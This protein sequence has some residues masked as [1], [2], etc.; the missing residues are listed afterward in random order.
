MFLHAVRLHHFRKAHAECALCRDFLMRTEVHR[1][2]TAETWPEEER[3]DRD[4][5]DGDCAKRP[6]KNF[7][8]A[9]VFF[10]FFE[11]E[12]GGGEDKGSY[13]TVSGFL[14]KGLAFLMVSS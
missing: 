9:G 11:T 4:Q 3:G 2:G 8:P 7:F 10:T 13:C 1:S 6:S 14:G 12:H 5:D